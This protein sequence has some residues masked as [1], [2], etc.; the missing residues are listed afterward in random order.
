MLLLLLYSIVDTV[1]NSCL[2]VELY[3][4]ADAVGAAA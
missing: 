4:A 1:H 2:P 3:A